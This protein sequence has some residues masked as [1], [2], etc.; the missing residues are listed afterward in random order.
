MKSTTELCRLWIDHR[1]STVILR[2]WIGID[3]RYP[4]YP[5]VSESLSTVDIDRD[6]STG[7][8]NRWIGVDIWLGVG[9]ISHH[10]LDHDFFVDVCPGLFLTTSGTIGQRSFFWTSRENVVDRFFSVMNPHRRSI[11]TVFFLKLTVDAIST[12]FSSSWIGI[13]RRY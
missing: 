6:R 3:R 11:S 13:D 5:R 10:S 8:I 4:P 1:Q 7:S 2:R 12:V 9:T